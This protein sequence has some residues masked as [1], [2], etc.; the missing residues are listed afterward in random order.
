MLSEAGRPR[1]YEMCAS[2]SQFRI[3]A[4]SLPSETMSQIEPQSIGQYLRKL[5][6]GKGYSLEEVAEATKI[7]LENLEALESD[8]ITR[9][10]P[11]IYVRGFIKNYAEFLGVD[12][13]AL[14]DTL[15]K[16]HG[17]P[18][19]ARHMPPVDTVVKT[20]TAPVPRQIPRWPIIGVA[21][22]LAAA[23]LYCVYAMIASP[24]RITVRAKGRVAVRVYLDG[25]F[26][27]A[28]TIEPGKVGYWQAKR[29]IKLRIA[30][31]ENAEVICR[32]RKIEL[33]RDGPASVILDH[34]GIRTMSLVQ[35]VSRGEEGP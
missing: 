2:L 8:E 20:Q 29:S 12:S 31:P 25:R 1:F 21:T 33:P 14:V 27:E 19:S 16:L 30:R 10:V 9:R 34:K 4:S 18:S 17:D 3:G 7:K 35:P 26:T 11:V 6:E 32:G 23:I 5:R 15:K 22:I 28:T 24:Y 13:D